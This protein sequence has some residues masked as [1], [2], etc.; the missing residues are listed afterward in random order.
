MGASRGRLVRQLLTQSTLL[1]ATG[2]AVAVG[3][4]VAG[5][6][7]LTLALPRD[8]PRASSI[9]V[10]APVLLFALATA[11]VATLAFGVVGAV[12]GTAG[13]AAG[14]VAPVMR[15]R[16]TTRRSRGAGSLVAAEVALG[17]V[18]SVLAALMVRSFVAL[19]RVDLGFRAEQVVVARVALPGDRYASAESQRA[20]FAALLARVRALPGVRAAGLASTR[21]L[22]GLGPA[23]TVADAERPAPTDAEAPVAD[24][25]YVDREFF[26][27]LR[28]PLL[29]GAPFDARER[30]NGAP[31]VVVS[32]ALART[33]WPGQRAVGRRARIA[34][35]GGI[36]AEV[37][38]VVG[39]VR[40]MEPRA[41]PRPTAYLAADRFPDGT[42]DLVVRGDG[43][44]ATLEASVR[45]ALATLD[46]TLPMYD[47]RTLDGLVGDALARDRFTTMLL[48][49]FA[50]LA[51]VLAA[52]GIFGV[53]STDVADRRAELG[54]RLALGA[55]RSAVLAQVVRQAVARAAIGV[56]LGAAAALVAARQMAALLFGVGA[57]DP[58]SFAG[59]AALLLAVAAV[60]AL[61]PAARAARISPVTA[62]RAGQ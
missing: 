43:S 11:F 36:D 2:A 10:D 15:E 25:R 41:A 60:A 20:F 12:R 19:R 24:V 39:D 59:V 34:M 33:L 26:R 35:F 30:P 8:T 56:A 37:A 18:L 44:P 40:L 7:L 9:R 49:A 51:L 53:L 48:G 23:T 45:A 14:S 54:I 57:A 61:V 4:A 27:A 31:R 29:A 32:E 52:V 46:P 17:L 50:T 6:R 22:G 47:V 21:P 28:I 55:R 42:R 3:V 38:G 13:G 62:M 16:W 1:G 5:V 58:V